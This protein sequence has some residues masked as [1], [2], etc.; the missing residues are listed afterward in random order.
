MFPVLYKK[1]RLMWQ[2]SNLEYFN[3][4]PEILSISRLFYFI[5]IYLNKVLNT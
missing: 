5:Q 4:E 1:K 3:Y 2:D